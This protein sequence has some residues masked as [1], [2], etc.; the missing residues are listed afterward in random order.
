MVQKMG[1]GLSFR[2]FGRCYAL[3]NDW[4]KVDGIIKDEVSGK[5]LR[6]QS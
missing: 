4:G 3:C 6:G 1:C 5:M 2:A